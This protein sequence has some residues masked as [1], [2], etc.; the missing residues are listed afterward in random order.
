MQSKRSIEIGVGFFV[1]LAFV[2]IFILSMKVSHLGNLFS[3][4]GY[5]V[6][7]DF[8]NV[9]GLKIK[10]P[11][12][13]AG[14]RIGRVTNIQFDDEYYQAIVTMRIDDQ[15]TKIPVD[16]V[17]SIFTAGMLGEQYIGFEAGVEEEYLVSDDRLSST[18]SA[19]ILEQLIGKFLYNMAGTNQSE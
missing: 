3:T 5:I 18:Q 2:A 15:F 11:I 12:K 9:G 8:S 14:V 7:A 19:M 6:I 1:A 10:S 13:M 17:A 16:T 4:N